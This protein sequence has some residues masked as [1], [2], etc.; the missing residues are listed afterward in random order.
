MTSRGFSLK[1]VLALAFGLLAAVLAGSLTLLIGQ[2]TTQSEQESIRNRLN[3]V[4]EV[5][6]HVLDIGMYE[7]MHD[8]VQLASLEQFRENRR[9][10]NNRQLLEGLQAGLPDYAWIGFAD[11]RGRVQY[12]TR[13]MLEGSDVRHES[14]FSEGQ[15][16]LFLGDVD[17]APQLARL[18]PRRA[19]D[20]RFIDI[21]IPIRDHAN[22]PVGVLGAHLSWDWARSVE[23]AVLTL[24]RRQAG[25]E[26]F[27]LNGAGQIILAP[28]GQ[29][30]ARLPALNLLDDASRSLRWPDGHDY[31]T[32][33]RLGQGYRD[34]PGLGW[35]VIARQP[36]EQ[37]FAVVRRLQ[38]YIAAAG[39]VV[40]LLF[41]LLGLWLA[42]FLSRPLSQL[43]TAAD[44]IR[45]GHSDTHLPQGGL[46]RE[47]RQLSASFAALL[48]RQQAHQNELA[49]LNTSLEQ[50]VLDRTEAVDV[51]NRHLMSLLEERSKM[52][53]EL[54]ALAATDSLTGL[55]NRRAFYERASIESKRAQRQNSLVSVV[56]FD[57]DHFKQVNDRFGHEAGDEV[58]RQS[59]AACRKQLRDID[60]MARF[61]GEEFVIL[62]PE[63]DLAGAT[64]VAERLRKALTDITIDT[65][66]GRLQ[67]SASFGVSLLLPGADISLALQAAD[68]ALYVAKHGG[69][70]RVEALAPE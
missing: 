27:I 55:L 63:T 10:A 70:N 22:R 9:P 35:R 33:T 49:H 3:T 26:I 69:R 59:A 43:A 68:K 7:R 39:V 38:S 1:G 47:T 11:T 20:W 62:L 28:P 37:A 45:Q 32:G 2:H 21:A 41:S 65:A 56:T 40:A 58:L 4:A 66:Q 12:A 52:M 57:L 64:L 17:K 24:S 36:T 50:Q 29:G 16:R 13:G 31:L 30:H 53:K 48:A 60:I 23:S 67:F 46:F 44:R 8:I 6:T 34:Y 14:W 51:A 5:T 18:L 54:E 15:Q 19:R 25:V 42:Y 61:G